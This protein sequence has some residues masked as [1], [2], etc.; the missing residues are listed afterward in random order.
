MT[1]RFPTETSSYEIEG[2]SSVME[3]VRYRPHAVT[4]VY[5]KDKLPG[6]F[7]PLLNQ[8][9]IQHRQVPNEKSHSK[10]RTLWAE[11]QITSLD[12]SELYQRLQG[13]E[14]AMTLLALDHLQDP[15][16]LGAIARSAAFFGVHYMIAPDRRQVLLTHAA[17]KTSQGAFALTELYTV[18]NLVRCL[19]KL[20]EQGYWIIGTDMKGEPM[21]DVARKFPKRVLVVGSEGTGLSNLVRRTCDVIATIPTPNPQLD[22]LN[23]SVATGISLYCLNS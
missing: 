10:N 8:H 18:T 12:E 3:Y 2:T 23:V 4:C 11:V 22:S 7:L 17:I 6:A 1:P 13:D 15:H 21:A 19:K 16:N 5:Y 20:Q 14:N 9:G